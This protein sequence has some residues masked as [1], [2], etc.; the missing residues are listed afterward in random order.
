MTYLDFN[1][2]A[3]PN[4]NVTLAGHNYS[5][6]PPS[7]EQMKVI[8][9]FAARAENDLQAEPGVLDPALDA[10]CEAQK[11]PLAVVTLGQDIYDQMIADGIDQATTDRVGYYG[12]HYWARGKERAD[13]LAEAMW[14]PKNEEAIAAAPKAP[15]DRRS[16][17]GRSTASASRTR[18]ASTPTTASP[19]D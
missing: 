17:S 6:A 19:K 10:I 16:K 8:L 13:F 15:Q 9:A 14:T 4:L 12:I 18:T 5:A 7:V 1:A 2:W 3:T 11:V